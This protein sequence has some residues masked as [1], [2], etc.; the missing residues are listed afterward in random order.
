MLRDRVPNNRRKRVYVLI[1]NEPVEA[2]MERIVKVIELGAETVQPA[3]DEAQ[4]PPS[5]GP[6]CGSTGPSS[7]LSTSPAGVNQ[8][9]WKYCSF[10]EYRRSRAQPPPGRR[11]DGDG[12]LAPIPARRER[13]VAGR[14]VG[15]SPARLRR[16]GSWDRWDGGTYGSAALP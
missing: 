9:R 3:G 2:C 1:G 5:A 4:R 12:G 7:S 11:A 15:R 8:R 13:T 16:L 14:G 10:A 6:G